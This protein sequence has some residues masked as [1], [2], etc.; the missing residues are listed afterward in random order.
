VHVIWF[1]W[2]IRSRISSVC[3]SAISTTIQIINKEK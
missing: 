1:N 2:N 3:E